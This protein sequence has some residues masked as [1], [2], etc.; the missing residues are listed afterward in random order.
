MESYTHGQMDILVLLVLSGHTIH[1]M[2]VPQ[3]RRA[4]F[5]NEKVISVSTTEIFN[6]Q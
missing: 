2:R 1:T 4:S 3:Y 5:G 6:V